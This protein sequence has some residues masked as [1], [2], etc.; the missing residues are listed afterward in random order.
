[1]HIKETEEEYLVQLT[2]TPSKLWIPIK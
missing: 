1:L 2:L